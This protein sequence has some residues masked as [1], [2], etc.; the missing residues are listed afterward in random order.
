MSDAIKVTTADVEAAYK[1][2]K[3]AKSAYSK[4]LAKLDGVENELIN[5]GLTHY[6]VS[7]DW[8]YVAANNAC[9]VAHIAY[10]EYDAVYKAMSFVHD[11]QGENAIMSGICSCADFIAGLDATNQ[12]TRNLIVDIVRAAFGDSNLDVKVCGTT[13]DRLVVSVEVDGD[14]HMVRVD[15]INTR[16]HEFCDADTIRSMMCVTP[17]VSD[18]TRDAVEFLAV[19]RVR[20]ID[21]LENLARAYRE[22]VNEILDKYR[23]IGDVLDLE[24]AARPF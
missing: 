5:E 9:E 4:A 13:N 6:Q 7:K 23:C 17:G 3:G 8:R 14:T 15:A 11:A 19:E 1:A 18:L 24:Y 16:T 22:N 10:R 12:K 20:A 21:R 2:R